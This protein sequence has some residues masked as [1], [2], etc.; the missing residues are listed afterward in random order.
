[1]FKKK[2]KQTNCYICGRDVGR[3]REI[4]LYHKSVK[5]KTGRTIT[6]GGGSNCFYTRDAS[7]T[8]DII[9][10]IKSQL[11]TNKPNTIKIKQNNVSIGIKNLCDNICVNCEKKI[12]DILSETSDRIQQVF[13]NNQLDYYDIEF[14]NNTGKCPKCKSG[15]LQKL[16]KDTTDD[17]YVQ[18]VECQATI[19]MKT[20]QKG[21]VISALYIKE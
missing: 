10:A 16:P 9:V 18:C 21:R 2:I 4:T 3:L 19:E 17:A 5:T 6:S 13:N 11:G 14:I 7:P 20:D 12:D 15:M 8:I 1:M